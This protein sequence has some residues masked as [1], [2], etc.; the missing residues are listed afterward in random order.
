MVQPAKELVLAGRS[1]FDPGIVPAGDMRGTDLASVV[2]QATELQPVVAA[3]AGIR[4]AACVVLRD[5]VVDDPREVTLE[6]DHVER[7]VE[8]GGDQPCIVRVIDRTAPLLP[9]PDVAVGL[10]SLA[11]GPQTHEDA[12]DLVACF[13]QERS[14]HRGV[15]P[16]AHRDQDLVT[17][18]THAQSL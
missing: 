14:R 10:E 16:S 11:G 13:L 9:D 17:G 2:V 8:L 4:G 1:R 6:V 7:H 18:G 5:E 12:D 15:N 3:H